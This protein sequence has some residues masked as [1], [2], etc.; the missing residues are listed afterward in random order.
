M[1]LGVGE[2]HQNK[3]SHMKVEAT[4]QDLTSN[5]FNTQFYT[6]IPLSDDPFCPF[7]LNLYPSTL[8]EEKF[9]SERPL[10]FSIL[11]IVLFM[12]AA[13]ALY[14]YDYHVEQ[15][16]RNLLKTA[17]KSDAIVSNML[18]AN[19]RDILYH[20]GADDES[21]SN[22]DD[23]KGVHSMFKGGVIAELYP[24]ATIVFADISRFTAWSSTR[25]PTQVFHL[26]EV[27]ISYVNL[28]VSCDPFSPSAFVIHTIDCLR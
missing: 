25:E 13:L 16:K 22:N 10:V 20:N 6:G 17:E 9:R 8:M 28:R 2:L 11:T 15:R 26:L 14:T 5:T 23:D 1:Y 24:S 3:F 7:T 19:V 27:C 21:I 12:V 18:P 4:Y